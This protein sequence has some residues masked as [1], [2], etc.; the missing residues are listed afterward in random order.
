MTN[1]Q[2]AAFRE[3]H[4]LTQRELAQRIG[5]GVSTLKD[6]ERGYRQD[7]NG[8]RRP[9]PFS[10]TLELALIA[11]ELGFSSYDGRPLATLALSNAAES[12]GGTIG[13]G[14]RKRVGRPVGSKYAGEAS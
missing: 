3:R 2:L 6:L 9:A 12:C 11:V 5:L 13:P 1:A 7:G 10:K 14:R 8:F 4:S